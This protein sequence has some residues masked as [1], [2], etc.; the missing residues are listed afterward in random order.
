MGGQGVTLPWEWEHRGC[1]LLARG[2]PMRRALA[3]V[4]VKLTVGYWAQ[5]SRGVRALGRFCRDQA[6][7]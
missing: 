2:G 6:P 4:M 1:H 3:G 5:R 7:S